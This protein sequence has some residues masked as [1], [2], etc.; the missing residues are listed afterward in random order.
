MAIEVTRPNSLRNAFND[1]RTRTPRR[2]DGHEKFTL[3]DVMFDIPHSIPKELLSVK[4][5]YV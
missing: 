4:T 5:L 2:G 1:L 3:D